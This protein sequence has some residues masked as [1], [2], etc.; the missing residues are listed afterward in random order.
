[1]IERTFPTQIRHIKMIAAIAAQ[2]ST[3]RKTSG[4]HL[5]KIRIVAAITLA[6]LKARND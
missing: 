3:R 4:S 5:L 1:M 2:A 6:P